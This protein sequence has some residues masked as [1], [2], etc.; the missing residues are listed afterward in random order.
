MNRDEIKGKAEKAKGYVKDK[1]GEILN[2]PDLE[3]EGEAERVAGTVREG[4]GKAKRTVREG[5]E[6]IADE[7][8]QQ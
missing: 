8:E 2:N 3:A 7:A 4:Y 1:A 5:I 6:D